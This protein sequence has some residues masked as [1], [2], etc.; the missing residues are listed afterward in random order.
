M[1]M[2]DLIYLAMQDIKNSAT[3][4]GVPITDKT[5]ANLLTKV[6][7]EHAGKE[8][9]VKELA[10]EINAGFK[11]ASVIEEIAPEVEKRSVGRPR[12][13][14]VSSP[15]VPVVNVARR[16]PGRPRKHPLAQQQSVAT[17]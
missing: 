12:K 2:N 13:I 16:G 15:E 10:D 5:V 17:G 4:N 11:F 8:V 1:K 7:E 6:I 14:I 3:S 9:T